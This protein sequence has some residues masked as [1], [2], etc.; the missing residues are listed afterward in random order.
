MLSLKACSDAGVQFMDGRH[1]YT[2]CRDPA[3]SQHLYAS[4]AGRAMCYHHPHSAVG[5]Q[6]M[7]TRTCP[8]VLV[9]LLTAITRINPFVPSTDGKIPGFV[10][11]V[12][13]T[14]AV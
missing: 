6:T 7:A 11:Q 14:Q 2:A 4:T 8:A 1:R 10:G 9:L 3:L 5:W 12:G 13:G